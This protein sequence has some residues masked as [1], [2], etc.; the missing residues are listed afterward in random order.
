MVFEEVGDELALV[1]YISETTNLRL[2]LYFPATQSRRAGGA[3][4]KE[5]SVLE[6]N[7]DRDSMAVHLP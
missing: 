7:V 1:S 2:D 3:W 4:Q 6:L 5:H